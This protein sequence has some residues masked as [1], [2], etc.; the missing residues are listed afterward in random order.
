MTGWPASLG[1]SSRHGSGVTLGA[2]ALVSSALGAC[3]PL[4]SWPEDAV[5]E[6][7]I[8]DGMRETGEP[9]VVALM[10]VTGLCTGTLIAPQ[11]VLTAKHC[12]VPERA[13]GPI[14]PSLVTVGI[15]DRVFGSSRSL[16]VREIVTTPGPLEISA[17][18]DPVSSATGTDIALLVLRERV[19]D[20]APIPVRRDSAEGLVSSAAV[21]IGFGNTRAG[22]SGLKN[23]QD[24]T[25]TALTPN[26]L[27]AIETICQGDSGGPLLVE[28]AGVR[29][30]AGVASFGVYSALGAV[31]TCPSDRDY[32]NRVDVQMALID[33]ALLRA[34][35]CPPSE[36]PRE[37]LCNS[38][39]DDCDGEV[40]EDCLALGESCTSDDECAF[41]PM[42]EGAGVTTDPEPV[43]CVDLGGG[44]RRCSIS[45]DATTAE[46]CGALPRPLG[47]GA[48][49][50]EGL[51]CR[52]VAG[53][54]GFCAPGAPGTAANGASCTADTDCVSLRCT[55]LGGSSIC[56]TPCVA[57]AGACPYG[58]VCSAPTGTTGAEACGFCASSG[59][60]PTGTCARR[61]VRRREPV[62]LGRLSTDRP[63]RSEPLHP[64]LRQRWRLPRHHVPMR[65][66]CMRPGRAR[67]AAR[68]VRDR[69]GL[70]PRRDVCGR[71]GRALLHGGLRHRRGLRRARA[72][73]HGRHAHALCRR[74]RAGRSELHRR[75]S[76]RLGRVRSGHLR[77]ALRSA[78]ALCAR[79]RV[80][81]PRGRRVL[82][83]ARASSS[84]DR[85]GQLR[86]QHALGACPPAERA[87]AAHP[88]PR[89]RRAPAPPR[90]NDGS[91]DHRSVNVRRSV[92]RSD[93]S[94]L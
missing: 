10:G 49:A 5:L 50:L 57:G 9:A 29:E 13:A 24:T 94:A 56:T 54:D 35:E 41:G 59:S 65:R 12:V 40:D 74:P 38:L 83:A 55:A 85:D 93:P 15:G 6:A 62:R 47:L 72:L 26:L 87:R 3:G 46:G 75:R 81:A 76:L 16:A 68:S 45:C 73:R 11:L 70:H 79:P 88:R 37:E 19:E 2:L 36:E 63:R 28:N 67:R 17:G 20:V 30:V 92:P 58:E 7:P 89:A 77:G 23:R 39:D 32:W 43:R 90:V 22:T 8:V 33:L 34:G 21:A 61:G 14:P 78:H 64:A 91:P 42:P 44:E 31:G 51:Y 86:L 66:R 60:F 82:R 53:C 84:A 27:E 4:D 80:H 18:R 25:I 69:G 71:R 1:R 52:S 48:L